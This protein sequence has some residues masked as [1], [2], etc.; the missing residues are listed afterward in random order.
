MQ[1]IVFILFYF[2]GIEK[3][4][5]TKARRQKVKPSQEN[6]EEDEDGILSFKESCALKTKKK[7]EEKSWA[8][9]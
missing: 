5:L 3:K 9:P 1:V 4:K 2:I 6:K 7:K 8:H